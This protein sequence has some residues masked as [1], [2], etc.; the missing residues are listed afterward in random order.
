MTQQIKSTSLQPRYNRPQRRL[1][2]PRMSGNQCPPSP[3]EP[4]WQGQHSH[5]HLTAYQCQRPF[6]DT[7]NPPDGTRT[8]ASIPSKHQA[9]GQSSKGGSL[10]RGLV[11]S[12]TG[13]LN[14]G[15][16]SL[17][18]AYGTTNTRSKLLD[19]ISCN[20]PTPGTGFSRSGRDGEQ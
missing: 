1:Q 12:N 5:L 3:L 18:S 20:G 16:S 4:E 8:K 9:Q 17:L 14:L 6:V 10:A 13:D 15:R 2:S 19:P 7:R 11:S